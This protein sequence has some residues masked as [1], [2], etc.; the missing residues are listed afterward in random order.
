MNRQRRLQN[1]IF[2]LGDRIQARLILNGRVVADFISDRIADM[3]ELLNAVRFRTRELRGLARLYIRNITRGWS[4][5]RPLML[6]T[7]DSAGGV[8]FASSCPS[9]CPSFRPSFPGR[10]M[11]AAVTVHRSNAHM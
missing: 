7:R 11:I 2:S 9:S 5:D 1:R 6:Y 8:G 10:S 3:T 4:E